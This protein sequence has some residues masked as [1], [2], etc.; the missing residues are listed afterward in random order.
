MM[1]TG[2]LAMADFKGAGARMQLGQK[3]HIMNPV[4][5]PKGGPIF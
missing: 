2:S 5:T 1:P 3:I 4:C